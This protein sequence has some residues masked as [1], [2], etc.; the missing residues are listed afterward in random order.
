METIGPYRVIRRLAVGGMGE[1]FLARSLAA[2][3][4][5]P[6]V[7]KTVHAR[8]DD[9]DR[10][11]KR[12]LD[13][14]R[15]ALQLSHKNIC[16]VTH[17]GEH[18]G[19]LFMAMELVPGR[20]LRDVLK[21]LHANGRRMT[22]A[23]SL[24]L[25]REI[26]DGLDYAH[27]ACDVATGAPL[28]LV[29]R[30]LS[31]SN[32]MISVEGEVKIID[33]GQAL[34]TMKVE[35]TAAG[36]VFGKLQYLS[37][38]QA[39]GEPLDHRSDLYSLAI[40]A[41]E[42]LAGA[43]YY[44]GVPR[45]R[46]TLLVQAGYRSPLLDAVDAPIRDMLQLALDPDRDARTASAEQMRTRVDRLL[47]QRQAVVGPS[48]LRR[49]LV[50]L[51][52]GEI[53]RQ[54]ATL[55][56]ASGSTLPAPP[57]SPPVTAPAEDDT[58]PEDGG[59]G[60]T[61]AIPTSVARALT[62]QRPAAAAARSPVAI[63]AVLGMAVLAVVLGVAVVVGKDPAPV[64]HAPPGADAGVAARPPPVPP[65]PVVPDA[66]PAVPP[67]PPLD[68]VDAGPVDDDGLA[69]LAVE[70]VERAPPPRH[71]RPRSTAEKLKLLER[72]KQRCASGVLDK[73]SRFATLSVDEAR[74]LA[75]ELE[76]CVKRCG[77]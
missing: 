22:P 23:L 49:L 62:R 48:D 60:V 20:D 6:C 11:R 8:H 40:L 13:E 64:V 4:A 77:R 55:A 56:E 65:A 57:S 9:D 45:E 24:Y 76:A 31:P 54:R 70:P 63:G 34:S 37:P 19:S 47:V 21:A 73:Y 53:E 36:I 17:V 35:R 67:A 15:L 7:V 32:V 33:F 39:R 51:F 71:A 29:H 27:R 1:V 28:Q 25:L 66:P 68:A 72:C 58:A 3:V 16:G 69:G 59:F 75:A 50:E 41:T 43:P 44:Q 2:G 74:V 42:L 38:E 5:R 52:P 12:F 61:E 46:L 26:L 30:D 18:D 14:A 10:A